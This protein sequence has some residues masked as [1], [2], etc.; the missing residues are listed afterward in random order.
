[1][2]KVLSS[3]IHLNIYNIMG[4]EII[5]L[6]YKEMNADYHRVHWTG[7]NSEV[8]KVANRIYFYIIKAEEVNYVGKII[9]LK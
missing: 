1:M 7:R 6:I 2:L 3:Q 5:T 8:E 4:Q 9:L